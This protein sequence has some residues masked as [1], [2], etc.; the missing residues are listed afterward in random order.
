LALAIYPLSTVFLFTPNVKDH[1]SFNHHIHHATHA[2]HNCKTVS[3][4]AGTVEA[5]KYARMH[6]NAFQDTF[7]PE[8]KQLMCCLLFSNRAFADT[9]YK[10][11]ENERLLSDVTAD[12]IKEACGLLGQVPAACGGCIHLYCF[13]RTSVS[14]PV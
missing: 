8:I 14:Q 2:P 7:M 13:A 1:A 12:F 3:E 10:N 9:P 4:F 11:L 6:F 5:L